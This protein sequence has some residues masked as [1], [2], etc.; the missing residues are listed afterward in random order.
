[1]K[2]LFTELN[3]LKNKTLKAGYAKTPFQLISK[4]LDPNLG[5]SQTCNPMQVDLR[6]SLK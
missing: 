5:K 4:R 2:Y 6:M 3:R 1:M